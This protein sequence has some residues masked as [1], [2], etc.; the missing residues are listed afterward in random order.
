MA[1]FAPEA[2]EQRKRDEAYYIPNREQRF[3]VPH[4]A[5]MDQARSYEQIFGRTLLRATTIDDRSQRSES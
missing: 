2:Q 3:Q 5:W 4:S 1:Y